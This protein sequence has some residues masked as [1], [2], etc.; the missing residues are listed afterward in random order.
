MRDFS[1]LTKEGRG[2]LESEARLIVEALPD[3]RGIVGAGAMVWDEV[4][5]ARMEVEDV[6]R[7]SW[8]LG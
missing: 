1:D 5:A 3:S 8:P 2:V 4:K 6:A 7:G